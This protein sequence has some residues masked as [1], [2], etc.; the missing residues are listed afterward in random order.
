MKDSPKLKTKKYN[1]FT[2]YPQLTAEIVGLS[3]LWYRRWVEAKF[4]EENLDFTW[5]FL[6]NNTEES[7]WNKCLE[8]YEEF[9]PKI[10]GGP[11]MMFLLLKRIRN[12]SETAIEALRIKVSTLKLSEMQ[13]EDVDI[14][15]SLVKTCHAALLSAS[16][17]E[18]S[19]VPDDFPKTVLTVL[20]TSSV[21]EFNAVFAKEVQD[22]QTQ[23]DKTNRRP[24][25]PTVS[26]TLK[27][28]TNTYQRLMASHEW[29]V[30]ADTRA[31]GYNVSTNGNR[32]LTCFNCGGDHLL[33][34]CKA[35]RNESKIEANRKA[36]NESKGR[37]SNNYGRGG[38]GRGRGG[39][40]GGR[41][42][43]RGP[44]RTKVVNGTPLV[45][46]KNG[47][48]VLD[49]AANKKL[50]EEKEKAKND[51]RAVI[52][53]ALTAGLQAQAPAPTP[54][55]P[56]APTPSQPAA[57]PSTALPSVDQIRNALSTMYD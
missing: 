24:I 54:T 49:T 3:N 1:L 29:N 27:L 22:V 46:N 16:T 38:R 5:K 57:L 15:V 8:D 26:S 53:S 25:W 35:P 56:L 45:M 2:D 39:G 21:P 18:H 30:P 37:S 17:K 52:E 10:Q 9:D 12:Q 43:G 40:R 32:K 36:F 31:A 47:A 34:D 14:V 11:L 44:R 20:Q 42:G 33:P 19:Y 7:L 4:I 48:Y 55:P 6:Q 28:A 50:K 13:G 51:A 41:G 23:A